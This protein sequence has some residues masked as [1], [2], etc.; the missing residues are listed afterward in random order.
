M[1]FACGKL[2]R[3]SSFPLLVLL[4]KIVVVASD[5]IRDQFLNVYNT[6]Y[7]D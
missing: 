4:I 6:L 2:K 1:V 5:V 3:V 7:V